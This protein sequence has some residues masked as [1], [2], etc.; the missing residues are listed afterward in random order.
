[1]YYMLPQPWIELLVLKHNFII[2]LW[3]KKSFHLLVVDSDSKNIAFCKKMYFYCKTI[4]NF[5]LFIH[6]K[7]NVGKIIHF[8]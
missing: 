2:F 5:Y 8:T 4:G 3:E 7:N 1:M 6:Q